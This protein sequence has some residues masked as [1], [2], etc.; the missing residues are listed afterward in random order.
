MK[1]AIL[2]TTFPAIS[3]TF[4]LNQITGLIDMG[5]EIDI[6]A[7]KPGKDRTVHS[8]IITYDLVRNTT[9]LYHPKNSLLRFLRG[10]GLIIY[11]LLKNT[12]ILF[13]ALKYF[14]YASKTRSLKYFYE[15][16]SFI[17]KR[18]Y[19]I[20]H[21]HFGHLGMTALRLREA[22]IINGRVVVTFHGFDITKY[23]QSEGEEFYKTLFKKAD[24]F[25]PVSKRWQ[26]K[27]INIGC[28]ED[29][30]KVHRMGVD[31]SLFRPKDISKTINK[32]VRILTI[33]RLVEKKGIEYG[34][35]ACE[36]VINKC[37]DIEYTIIGDGPL[38]KKLRVLIE[39]LNLSRNVH[40]VN[41]G[42]Q[43]KIV[44]MLGDAD[45]MLAPS[46]TSSDGNQEGIPVVIMEAMASGLAVVSTLH[47]GIP[48]LVKNGS[49]GYLVP[50]RDIPSLA[51]KLLILI[52]DSGLRLRMGLEGRKE[53]EAN[54][55]I[56]TLNE[57][58]DELFKT[59]LIY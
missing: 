20:V 38:E 16:L 29:K 12:R 14:I 27:L 5:H 47:S 2:V 10:A 36:L 52:N 8:D 3:Q 32:P 58:L 6:Y 7:N 57:E 17:G 21:C 34:I 53:I 18:G 28:D 45:I 24:L 25:L 44:R 40:L 51:E 23:L 19:D 26:E 4:V 13:R 30:I 22:G 33:G 54:Y 49:T 48:E 56:R 46:V 1:I 9:Y 50:E 11:H 15:S 42:D 35:K 55:N 31:V 59:L 37:Q 43:D 41:S 39:K